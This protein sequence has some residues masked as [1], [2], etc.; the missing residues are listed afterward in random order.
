MSVHRIAL[1]PEEPAFDEAQAL[2]EELDD[3]AGALLAVEGDE[4][5]HAVRVKRL[6][7]REPV[8]VLADDGR[9][10]SASFDHAEKLGKKGGWRVI[11][12]VESART[13]DPIRPG[14]R[15]CSAA[16]KGPRLEWMIDQLSQVGAA[17]WCP[18]ITKRSVT[19]PREG[20]LSRLARVSAEAGK[21]CGRSW[22]LRIEREAVLDRLL[23]SPPEGLVVADASGTPYEPTGLDTLTLL[24]GPEGGFEDAELARL[25]D[26][27]ARIARFGP[28]VMRV[29]T[30]SVVA[31]GQMIELERNAAIAATGGAS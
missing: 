31:A 14:L 26:A 6:E 8:E 18:L 27:G 2:F 20:K 13:E 21:Q 5:H 11:L 15:V 25:R 30:A 9:V 12:R 17:A 10:I 29:E 24:V 4:A 1:T 22:N 19:E 28:H 7:P 3:P 16:P 23:A